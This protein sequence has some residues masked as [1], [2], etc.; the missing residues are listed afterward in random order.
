MREKV[1]LIR[2][3]KEH[4]KVDWYLRKNKTIAKYAQE[5]GFEINWTEADC[6][7]G[8]KGHIQRSVYIYI[9]I[10]MYEYILFRGNIIIVG[11][12]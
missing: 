3:I 11:A 5:T 7:M 10:Y 4:K 8:V 12:I 2:E 1:S 9:Y 6:L